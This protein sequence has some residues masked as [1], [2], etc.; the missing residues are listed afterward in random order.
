[1]GLNQKQYSRRRRVIMKRIARTLLGIVWLSLL[2]AGVAL[3]EEDRGGKDHPLFNRMPGTWIY[4]YK[5]VDFD[6]HTFIDEKGKKVNVEGRYYYIHY[7]P[8]TGTPQ[9]SKLKIL[10]N[11]ENA[12]KKIGGV[13]LKS[14][15]DDASYMKL[16]KG[17]KEIWVEVRACNGQEPELF[18][19]EKEAMA[20]EIVANAE[21]FSN[22][23]KETGHVAVYGIYFD[24]GQSVIKPESEAAMSEIAK[25]L[26]K[27]AGLKVNV[28]GHTDNVGGMDSNMKLSQARADAVVQALVGK[29]GIDANRLKAYGVGPLAPVASND[30]EEGKAK[31]RRVELVKQ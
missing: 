29:Y 17:G 16:V 18:I 11:Y 6:A 28:V 5:A 15:L 19:I 9:L 25:L 2:I 30:T 27:E 23:L 13:V 26:K 3:A 1:M 12:V 20:H 10:R 24:T 8:E 22:D 14:D 7:Y 21:A 4:S 31:N